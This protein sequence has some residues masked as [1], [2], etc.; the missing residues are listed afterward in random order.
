MLQRH[1]HA[2]ATRVPRGPLTT[3][4]LGDIAQYGS[5]YR[6]VDGFVETKNHF[7]AIDS[8]P[9]TLLLPPAHRGILL[10][11]VEDAEHMTTLL[12]PW[13][14][15]VVCCGVT[16]RTGALALQVHAPGVRQVALGT[17][18]KPPFDGPVDLRLCS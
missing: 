5:A 16:T 8:A 15:L 17:M 14:Q 13:R 1:L 9:Q 18:Q 6:A 3:D 11:S 2:A 7:I 12:Q 4:E 10:A